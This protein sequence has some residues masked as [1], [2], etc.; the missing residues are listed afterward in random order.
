M[1][2]NGLGQDI[3]AGGEFLFRDIQNN[4]YIKSNSSTSMEFA[5]DTWTQGGNGTGANFKINASFNCKKIVL[6]FIDKDHYYIDFQ[7]TVSDNSTPF[8]L[9]TWGAFNTL[10]DKN[11][12]RDGSVYSIEIPDGETLATGNNTFLLQ[13]ASSWIRLDLGVVPAVNSWFNLVMYNGSGRDDISLPVN[14]KYYKL[15]LK[16]NK[17]INP[18]IYGSTIPSEISPAN[19]SAVQY[20]NSGK[21]TFKAKITADIPAELAG[22]KSFVKSY[23]VKRNNVVIAPNETPDANGNLSYI[24]VTPVFGT[25]YNYTV[26]C[27]YI[28]YAGS[29][30]ILNSAE[31][32]AS[33]LTISL[34]TATNIVATSKILYDESKGKNIFVGAEINWTGVL[35]DDLIPYNVAYKITVTDK[36]ANTVFSVE[37]LNAAPYVVYG[38]PESDIKIEAVYTPKLLGDVFTPVAL[39]IPYVPQFIASP[40]IDL[41]ASE[42]QAHIDP[43]SGIFKAVM[44]WAPAGLLPV[45]YYEGYRAD[46]TTNPTPAES[47]YVLVTENGNS[48]FTT[49]QFEDIIKGTSTLADN[50]QVK[51]A[52]KVLPYYSIWNEPVS[53]S[54]IA[55]ADYSNY[56]KVKI[57]TP[58]LGIIP[59][60]EISFDQDTPTSVESVLSSGENIAYPSPTEGDLHIQ[61]GE[62]IRTVKLLNLSSGSVCK[63]LSFDG[64]EMAVDIDVSDLSAGL[65]AIIVN[66]V[67]IAKVMKK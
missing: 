34:S 51:F 33:P 5:P 29:T 21:L 22:L 13:L 6:F 11:F 1:V 65:Y 45:K 50:A 59:P 53:A 24:D 56:A 4:A 18:Q 44:Q 25:T 27:N 12:K 46:I 61:F 35:L 40:V 39:S 8:N 31:V 58:A 28:D 57:Q 60:V 17:S 2:N 47:D 20:T 23:T 48:E 38:I 64:T 67:C 30:D 9:I 43:S 41:E 32:A 62:P 7:T 14:Q 36:S 3:T 19:V 63:S 37:D 55:D 52:Y 16:T 49:T 15:Y 66:D 42:L 26:V 10:P 54:A